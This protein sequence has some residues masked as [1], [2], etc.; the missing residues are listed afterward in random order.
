MSEPNAQPGAAPADGQAPERDVDAAASVGSTEVQKLRAEAAKYRTERNDLRTRLESLEEK[1]REHAK[2]QDSQ[3]Q[4]RLKVQ[5]EYQ[6]LYETQTE[7]LRTAQ[8][9]VID[10]E[11]KS[12][13][14]A[15]GVTDSKRQALLMPALRA[16]I[17]VDV[18]DDFTVTGNFDS[19]ISEA[20]EILGLGQAPTAT[21]PAAP[22]TPAQPN[23]V[24][25]LLSQSLP[26]PDRG[27]GSANV[28][29][30]MK[31]ALLRG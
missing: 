29:D 18:A 17:S 4:Q 16:S 25:L 22:A 31:A 2:Q 19:A 14:A 13:L 12:R 6:K 20:V 27:N 1:Q 23:Q 24:A 15:A 10:G 8:S 3:E 7:K 30:Q 9:R 28:L 21:T 26:Q 11:I 5:G